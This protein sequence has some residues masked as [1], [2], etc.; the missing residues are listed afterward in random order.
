MYISMYLYID[1]HL[2][3][4]GKCATGDPFPTQLIV[5]KQNGGHTPPVCIVAHPFLKKDQQVTYT[6]TDREQYPPHRHTHTGPEQHPKRTIPPTPTH[7][8]RTRTTPQTPKR[9]PSTNT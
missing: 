4:S 2:V 5:G 8:H 3:K 1:T 9:T 7:T 6:H